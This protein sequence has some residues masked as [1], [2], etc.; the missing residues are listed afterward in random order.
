MSLSVSPVL[1][2]AISSLREISLKPVGEKFDYSGAIL[3]CVGL[4]TILIGLTI[5]RSG[6]LRNI[7]IMGGRD[8]IILPSAISGR[9]RQEPDAGCEAV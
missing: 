2:S 8:N 4:L 6:L 3:Y 7:I 1:F 5:G 9:F